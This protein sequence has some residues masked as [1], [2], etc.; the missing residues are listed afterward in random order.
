MTRKREKRMKAKGGKDSIFHGLKW[1]MRKLSHLMMGNGGPLVH[2]KFFSSSCPTKTWT[3]NSDFHI[4]SYHSK[5]RSSGA[6][7]ELLVIKS[8]LLTRVLLPSPPPHTKKNNFVLFFHFHKKMLFQIQNKSTALIL[9][10]KVSTYISQKLY[11]NI[12]HPEVPQ[13]W[14]YFFVKR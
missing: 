8:M 9:I 12:F 4:C 11:D 5:H 10:S 6:H 13:S 2:T 3:S 1:S 14:L 7:A